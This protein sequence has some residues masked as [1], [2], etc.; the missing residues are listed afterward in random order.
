MGECA[1]EVVSLFGI[2]VVKAESQ[3]FDAQCA[4]EDGDYEQAEELAYQ[5]MCTAARS[6]VRTEF[7]DVTEDPD[8]IVPEFRVRFFDSERFFDKYAKGKFGSYLLDRFAEEPDRIDRAVAARRVEE[9]LLF[10]EATHACEA[11][12]SASAS[13]E[14]VLPQ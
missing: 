1:G 6:L 14:V 9:S 11:R 13:P 10:I 2:E 4:L 12:A 7:I 3:A 5:A 8:S